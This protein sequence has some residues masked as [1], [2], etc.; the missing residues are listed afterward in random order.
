MTKT[1]SQHAGYAAT[2]AKLLRGETT[3]IQLVN[4]AEKKITDGKH[5]NAFLSVFPDKAREQALILDKKIQAGNAGACAGM[6]IAVKDNISM[7][8][9]RLTCASKILENFSAVY[10]ATVICRLLAQDAIIIGKTNMDEFA[11]GSSTENSA[12]RPSLNPVDATRTPGGSSGGSAVAVAAGMSHASL[13]SETGGSVRQPAAMCGVVGV[14]PTY[15]RVSR[16]GLVAFASSFDQIG[17]I[18]SNVE[19]AALVLQT[20]AGYD[21]NDST[22]VSTPVP[23]YCETLSQGCKGLRI[24]VPKEYLGRGCSDSVQAA[25]EKTIQF[26]KSEGMIVEPVSLPHTE[27]C[28]ATYYIL[29]TAEASSNLAR[30]DGVR[31]GFR[32]N[33]PED[34]TDMYVRSRTEGFGAEVKRRIMLGTFVLSAGYYDSYY[35]KAQKIRRRIKEDFDKA[36]MN[37]DAIYTPTTPTTAFMLGEKA[38]D[39]LEMYLNDIYTSSANIAG[40]PGISVPIGNDENGL[41]I[42]GQIMTKDFDEVTMF[43]IAAAIERNNP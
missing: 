33:N 3:C 7:R 12:F 29:T 34:L 35:M 9:H 28:I 32:V 18:A 2:R 1:S 4:E 15:G 14:K 23:N 22:S 21:P 20:I 13:G 40:I 42:G 11:M 38:S 37:C 17:P 6:V 31:Y 24:G 19:D 43:R 5:L 27:Y 25:I 8:N 30:Y 36:F 39:P 16:W 26:F 41:P 10:D